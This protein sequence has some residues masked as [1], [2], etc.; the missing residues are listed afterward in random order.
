ML[1]L[2]QH[3]HGTTTAATTHR[4][5]STHTAAQPGRASSRLARPG[6]FAPVACL[7]M[8]PSPETGSI[9]CW[10]TSPQHGAALEQTATAESAGSCVSVCVSCSAR[11]LCLFIWR[12]DF[13]AAAHRRCPGSPASAILIFLLKKELPHHATLGMPHLAAKGWSGIGRSR[14]RTLGP[15]PPPS[16]FPVG[17]G[18]M[19]WGARGV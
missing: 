15:R 9:D 6:F 18:G 4:I 12:G 10:P 11:C 8:S 17:A 19:A 3:Q 7:S 5:I 13:R 14:Q 16:T 2:H 1:A